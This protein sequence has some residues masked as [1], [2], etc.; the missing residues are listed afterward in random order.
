MRRAKAHH[1][2]KTPISWF[3]LAN[4]SAVGSSKG[5]FTRYAEQP[6]NNPLLCN[7]IRNDDGLGRGEKCLHR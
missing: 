1:W 7:W 5:V 6:N 3:R 4:G 2:R